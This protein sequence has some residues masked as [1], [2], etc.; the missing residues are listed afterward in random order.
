MRERAKETG[1]PVVML[2]EVN[3]SLPFMV[4]DAEVGADF[5]DVIFDPG[6]PYF[7]LFPL[8]HQPIGIADYAA[9]FHAASLVEDGGAL[10]VGIGSLGDAITRCLIVRHEMPDR[11]AALLDEIPIQ[12]EHLTRERDRFEQGLYGCSEMVVDGLIHLIEA[13]IL[14]RRVFPSLDF[15]QRHIEHSLVLRALHDPQASAGHRRE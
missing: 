5:F 10:Q 12:H 9:G 11:H 6:E 2:G 4:N 7:T 8:P 14:T 13:G 3:Q 1:R 15:E